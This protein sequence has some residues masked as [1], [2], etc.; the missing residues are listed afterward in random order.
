MNLA[1]IKQKVNSYLSE[2]S[3]ASRQVEEEQTN[4]LRCEEKLVNAQIAQKICQEVGS[5]IQQEAHKQISSVVTRCLQAVFEDDSYEFRIQFEQKR[6]KT[7][8]VL[9]FVREEIQTDPLNS[10]G[11]GVIDVA[12][13]ALRL[14]CLLL[15]RPRK[16]K[17]L[18]MD[19]PFRFLSKSYR[20]KI[21]VLL[22]TLA[23]EFSLQILM[24]THSDELITGRVIEIE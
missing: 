8:A 11:G 17:L 6:G 4:L 12:A 24:I 18:V 21:K 5:G 22:E 2:L 10:S 16:R 3:L 7:E 19:E 20:P 13:F 14:A 15:T 23:K 1:S 9:C